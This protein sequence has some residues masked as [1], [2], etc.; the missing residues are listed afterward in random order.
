METVQTVE[1]V[2]V[3]DK[4]PQFP[5]AATVVLLIFLFFLA[6]GFLAWAIINQLT[7][8]SDLLA[9]QNP[10]CYGTTCGGDTSGGTVYVSEGL[11]QTTNFCIV[12]APTEGFQRAVEACN[13]TQG[14]QQDQF[15]NFVS[16]YANQYTPT[17]GPT[18]KGHNLLPQSDNSNFV[19][20][21]LACANKL[22]VAG[23]DLTSIKDDLQKLRTQ[24]GN[25]CA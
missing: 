3:E 16:F 24:C 23:V 2:T 13:F 20:T 25:R 22:D 6:A 15:I 7:R 19:A 17:C 10:Y 21:T 5:T 1:T 8:Q 4:R 14:E 11:P 12:N 18:W 9:M